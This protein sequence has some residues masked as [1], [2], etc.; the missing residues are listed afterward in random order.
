[1][2]KKEDWSGFANLLTKTLNEVIA[3]EDK[4]IHNTKFVIEDGKMSYACLDCKYM[5][6]E[7]TYKSLEYREG[8][9]CPKCGSRNIS[10][11]KS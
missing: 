3:E 7:D 1:M 2:K 5:W 10:G 8:Y 6:L 4:T 11:K 9:S